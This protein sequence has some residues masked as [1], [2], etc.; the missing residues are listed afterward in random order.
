MKGG[1]V[2]SKATHA[3]PAAAST[4][5]DEFVSIPVP[6]AL[7]KDLRRLA[8][9]DCSALAATARRLLARSVDRELAALA[10]EAR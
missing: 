6:L 10:A 2:S 8:A 1:C 4:R 5:C 7:K 9:H 3:I